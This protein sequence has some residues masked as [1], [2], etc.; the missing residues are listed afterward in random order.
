MSDTLRL[1]SALLWRVYWLTLFKSILKGARII[2]FVRCFALITGA[3]RRTRIVWI[4]KVPSQAN[5]AEG[6]SRLE[7]NLT[8]FW[9]MGVANTSSTKEHHCLQGRTPVQQMCR[10]PLQAKIALDG[11]ISR[12]RARTAASAA[13]WDEPQHPTPLTGA[14]SLLQAAR[15]KVQTK[16][17]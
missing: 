15:E 6:P 1:V 13:N 3:Q 9:K 4:A 11:R 7:G 16:Y 2:V 14:V 17:W 8:Q 5:L 12:T 10:V